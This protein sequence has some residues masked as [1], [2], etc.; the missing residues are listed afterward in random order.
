MSCFRL[1]SGLC[2][3]FLLASSVA[4]PEEKPDEAKLNVLQ[5]D[6][7]GRPVL[8]PKKAQGPRYLIWQADGQWHLRTRSSADQATF[9]GT[10]T[11]RDGK[12]TEIGNFEDL[13]TRKRA[14]RNIQDA[15]K[16]NAARDRIAFEFRTSVGEDGFDFTLGPGA[17]A[18]EFDLKIDEEPNPEKVYLGRKAVSPPKGKFLLAADPPAKGK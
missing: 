7:V 18:L 17:T 2:L 8:G 16:L 11:V 13:E 6:P 4:R 5:V 12:V 14:K 10:V 1:H 3:I 15:G 9:R